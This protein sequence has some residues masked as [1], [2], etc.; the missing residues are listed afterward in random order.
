[1]L[2][3]FDA[4]LEFINPYHGSLMHAAASGNNLSALQVL[5]EAGVGYDDAATRHTALG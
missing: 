4:D 2:L 5:L 1:M 3:N